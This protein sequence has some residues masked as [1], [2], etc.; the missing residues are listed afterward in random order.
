M[1]NSIMLNTRLAAAAFGA[2]AI[3]AV[4]FSNSAA[5]APL[6][7]FPF[8]LT[9]P[10]AAVQPPVQSMPQAQE[11]DRS[12]EL[13]ARLRRQVVAYPTREAPG[14]VIIDTPHTYLYLV[15]GGGQAM[16]YGIGV[17]R[18][19]FTW[20][21]TQTITKKAEW[22]DWTPPPEMIARQPYLP[23]HMAGGPGNPLGARAM[24]L[25]G[26]V[27]RI[28]GTNAPETIGTHVSSG[29]LRL[30]NED[31][32]DLYSRVSVGTKV[33]VLPMTDRRAA[34]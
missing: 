5:A 13:P 4:A 3:G 8:I 28:H 10:T 32:T 21:G 20:S 6:P 29:C 34:L 26:T 2:L 33:I 11:E 31:V 18:D 7:M 15:L 9:P 30:T 22:P 23:R 24:Y 1:F 16:R 27:Y 25:G 17:G 14:T 19:G 12:V